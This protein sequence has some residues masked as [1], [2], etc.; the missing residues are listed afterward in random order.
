MDWIFAHLVL[1]HFPIILAVVASLAAVVAAVSGRDGAWRYAIVTGLLA[2]VAA[3][4][5]FLTG[6][7]AEEVAESLPRLAEEAI[8]THEHWGL[9]ALIALGV[10]GVLAVLALAL[11]SRGTRW[12]FAVG[13]WAAT[14]VMLQTALHG[15]EIEHSEEARTGEVR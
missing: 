4:I 1:N 10:A 5:A 8:E 15:G 14:G 13:M 9:Y 3:P 6:Q 2:A 11:K 12:L 7:Q